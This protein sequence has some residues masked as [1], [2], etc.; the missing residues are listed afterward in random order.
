MYA[1]FNSR[2]C[3]LGNVRR[4]DEGAMCAFY[5]PPH[6]PLNNVEIKRAERDSGPLNLNI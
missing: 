1:C 4:Q 3:V 6:Q 5:S 2:K